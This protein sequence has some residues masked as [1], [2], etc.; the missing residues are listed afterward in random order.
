MERKIDHIPA[1]RYS[2][3]AF[4]FTSTGCYLKMLV[5]YVLGVCF[6]PTGSPCRT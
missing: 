4:Y 1:F 6:M 2:L 5:L 3:I